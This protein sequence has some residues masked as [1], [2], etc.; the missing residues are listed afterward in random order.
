[1][2]KVIKCFNRAHLFFNTEE[3][4]PGWIPPRRRCGEELRHLTKE[5]AGAGENAEAARK[6][7]TAI[8]RERFGVS[9]VT[10]GG[11]V[12]VAEVL[13]QAD[14]D[15][16]YERHNARVS[17]VLSWSMHTAIDAVYQYSTGVLT[18]ERRLALKM[19]S[20]MWRYSEGDGVKYVLPYIPLLLAL[21][22]QGVGGTNGQG[23]LGPT[24]PGN[25]NFFPWPMPTPHSPAWGA[26]DAAMREAAL[27]AH[28]AVVGHPEMYSFTDAASYVAV[29][30]KVLV[31]RASTTKRAEEIRVSSI[32]RMLTRYWMWL[33]GVFPQSAPNV[34][35]LPMWGTLDELPKPVSAGLTGAVNWQDVAEGRSS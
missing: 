30:G 13:I 3:P 17:A 8:L 11:A 28:A 10:E 25:A 26:W 24:L 18:E 32:R 20:A 4:P 22:A 19:R 14:D 33:A 35:V 34:F 1:M 15:L 12:D 21:Q 31:C 2:D 27:I 9:Q 6:R 7:L 29:M 5:A 16:A 23:T